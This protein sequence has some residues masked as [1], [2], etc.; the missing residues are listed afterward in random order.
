MLFE[1]VLN[2]CKAFTHVMT[3]SQNVSADFDTIVSFF[4]I[5][6][7]FL[8]RLSLLESRLP[9]NKVYQTAIIRVFSSIL[10]VCGIARQYRLKGRFVK[11]A[12]A[13]VDGQDSDL[14]QKYEDLQKQIQ[15]LES[16]AIMATLAT[17]IDLSRDF[18][19]FTQRFT[20]MSSL[21]EANSTHTIETQ[22]SVKEISVRLNTGFKSLQQSIMQRDG[23]DADMKKTNLADSGAKRVRELNQLRR[24]LD[25]GGLY[26][27]ASNKMWTELHQSYVNGTFDWIR[28]E[29]AYRAMLDEK[30][31]LLC[32]Q[33]PAGIGKSTA[34]Y[35]TGLGLA[36]DCDVFGSTTST[37]IAQFFSGRDRG[38][39][40][41]ILG[42][43]AMQVADADPDY[44]RELLKDMR[45]RR[46]K[47]DD[48]F[49]IFFRSKFGKT[50]NRRLI[51]V[52]DLQ[53]EDGNYEDHVLKEASKNLGQECRI[54]MVLTSGTPA[55]S[56]V[57]AEHVYLTKEKVF[58]DMHKVATATCTSLPRLC[59]SRAAVLRRIAKEVADKA[60]SMLVSRHVCFLWRERGSV[61][62]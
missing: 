6:N 37:Y 17:T 61:H 62:L 27:D 40:Q 32:I 46:N 43:C 3:A 9:S 49:E 31:S 51:L 14:Q 18:T 48:P 19:N 54:Q 35:K 4:D 5:M 42:A 8:E 59:Q 30:S 47:V 15:D 41:L 44:R 16:L 25:I 36:D 50:S 39:F 21:I 38:S 45:Q 24:E 56:A 34:A 2:L 28:D 12:H 52:L 53:T 26:R 10:A 58:Q 29:D 33:G 7:N 1:D 57:P 23:R 13:L 22:K 60:D 11:W 20:A 55:E